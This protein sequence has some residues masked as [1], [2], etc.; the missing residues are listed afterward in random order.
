M[1]VEEAAP[2]PKPLSTV[3]LL[4]ALVLEEEGQ[5]RGV[6]GVICS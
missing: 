1:R 5:E 2:P 4:T 3:N 6:F